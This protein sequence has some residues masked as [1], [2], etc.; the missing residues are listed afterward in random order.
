MNCVCVS[1]L[2][3]AFWLLDLPSIL[4]E[5]AIDTFIVVVTFEL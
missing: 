1:V 3:W 4:T 2:K 5:I